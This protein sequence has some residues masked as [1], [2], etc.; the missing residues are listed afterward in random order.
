MVISLVLL[1]GRLAPATGPFTPDYI[2]QKGHTQLIGS[3]LF[4]DFLLPFEISSL[5][6]LVAIIGVISLAKRT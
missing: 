6:L 1:N 2:A 5:L 4:T 3:L